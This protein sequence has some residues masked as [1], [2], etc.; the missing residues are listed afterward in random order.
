ML[1]IKVREEFRGMLG[2]TLQATIS[3]KRL[4]IEN[5]KAKT[6]VIPT[7]NK[8][9]VYYLEEPIGNEWK[10]VNYLKGGKTRVNEPWLVAFDWLRGWRN[11][12]GQSLSKVKQNQT[13][14]FRL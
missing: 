9:E 10:H 13:G 2:K 4:S 6:K 11:F 1:S 8:S 3:M 14:F 5:R 7:A 12:L